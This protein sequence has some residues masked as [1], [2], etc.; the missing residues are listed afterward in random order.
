[1]QA[2]MR[3]PPLYATKQCNP[4]HKD[5][6]EGMRM[7]VGLPRLIKGNF[8]GVRIIRSV[9]FRNLLGVLGEDHAPWLIN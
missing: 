5:C 7:G 3:T 8:L 6:P 1:M 2:P 9:I 4:Q